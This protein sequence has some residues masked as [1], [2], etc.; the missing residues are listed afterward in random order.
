M[1][2]VAVLALAAGGSAQLQQGFYKGKCNGT[3]VEAVVQ[4]IVKSWFAREPPVVAYLLRM[5]F[6]ECVING[7]DGGLLIDGPGTEKTAPPNL[8]VKGYEVIAAIKAELERRCPGVVSCSDIQILATRDAVALGGGAAYQVRTGRRDRR[9]SLA[10]DVKLPSP[11]YTAAQTTAYYGR[12]GLSAFDTV[13][14]LGA[15]TVGATRCAAIK[16]SR[17]YAYGG[18]SGA[19]DPGLDPAYAF[20]YKTY[21]CPNVPSSDNNVVFL[22]DQWSALKVD[23]HYYRNLQLRRGVLP[24]DQNLYNDGSTRWIVDLLAN[25]AGLFTSLFP[26][27]LVKL[28]E[29]NVLIGTQGEIRKVCN[30]FN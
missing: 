14:L 12:L 15:H 20:V 18:R 26:Q 19:T 9:R 4:G 30:R 24:C 28:S 11:D 5:Q 23:N 21:V 13:L 10:S 16:S 2:A 27:A 1:V 17:L 25:N 22:D 7:C 6:H 29:V 8:S 3:D